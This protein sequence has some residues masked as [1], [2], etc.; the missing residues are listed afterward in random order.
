MPA[1][2]RPRYSYSWG[3]SVIMR[4]VDAYP[5]ASNMVLKVLDISIRQLV[6]FIV[7]GDEVYPQI[8]QLIHD[9]R[10]FIDK[11]E[12]S[13]KYSTYVE[14]LIV[15]SSSRGWDRLADRLTQKGNCLNIEEQ[16]I[17]GQGDG[18][19]AEIPLQPLLWPVEEWDAAVKSVRGFAFPDSQC[20]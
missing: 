2:S 13:S 15:K 17:K 3:Y 6:T 4:L 7:T 16:A 1:L 10:F 20:R 11:P 19:E 12:V 14:Y 9:T 8:R 5:R 18:G